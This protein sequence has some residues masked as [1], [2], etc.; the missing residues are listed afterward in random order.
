M[1]WRRAD[2]ELVEPLSIACWKVSSAQ[3][4]YDVAQRLRDSGDESRQNRPFA[5]KLL[6][7]NVEQPQGGGVDRGCFKLLT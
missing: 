6:G 7:A 1:Q 2:A 3:P 5:I 4:T